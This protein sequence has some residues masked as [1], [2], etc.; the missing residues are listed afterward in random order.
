[1]FPK[2]NFFNLSQKYTLMWPKMIKYT[3][4]LTR[5]ANG[6]DVRM[7]TGWLLQMLRSG[8]FGRNVDCKVC[9]FLRTERL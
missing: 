3:N 9:P 2:Y 7:R 4:I 1:M 6:G 5:V 8:S